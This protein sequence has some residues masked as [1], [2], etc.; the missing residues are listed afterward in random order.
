MGYSTALDLANSGLTL[1]DSVRYH[2]TGNFYP[3]IPSSMT[4]P[5]VQ[6]I[7]NANT[8]N[9]NAEVELPEGITYRGSLTAP[10]MALIEAHRLDFWIN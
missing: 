3:P 9:W 6:A 2:L 5:C 1:E 7:Q 10:T 8:G 4:E